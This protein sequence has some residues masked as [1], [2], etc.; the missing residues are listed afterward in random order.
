M[1]NVQGGLK[2]QLAEA[3][4]AHDE[5]RQSCGDDLREL[6][7]QL[8]QAGTDMA[9]YAVSSDFDSSTLASRQE[10]IANKRRELQDREHMLEVLSDQREAEHEAY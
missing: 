7:A 1:R 6:A 10:E 3:E 8:T 5:N 9:K 4:D 2:T